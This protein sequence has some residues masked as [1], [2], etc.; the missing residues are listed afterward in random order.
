MSLSG[1][2]D[3]PAASSGYTVTP[4][5]PPDDR[6]GWS[7][8]H[9]NRTEICGILPLASVTTDRESGMGSQIEHS[10]AV[11]AGSPD[12]FTSPPPQPAGAF[13]AIA[14]L[15]DQ[16]RNRVGERYM[17]ARDAGDD[18]QAG[19]LDWEIQV[20]RWKA[21]RALEPDCEAP[22]VILECFESYPD[23]PALP[24][25]CLA[26]TK[27][28]ERF[29]W[30][31]VLEGSGG[32]TIGEWLKR[33]AARMRQ[34]QIDL[35]AAIKADHHDEIHRLLDEESELWLRREEPRI[36]HGFSGKMFVYDEIREARTRLA[37]ARAED[38]DEI[39]RLEEEEKRLWK[40]LDKVY[41]TPGDIVDALY[42][43][44]DPDSV[45]P[46]SDSSEELPFDPVTGRSKPD[47]R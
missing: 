19:R 36:L 45:K 28:G 6:S 14:E 1:S 30:D 43:L 44:V 7:T 3:L 16:A 29:V 17:E 21:R 38:R 23:H 26:G 12:R 15:C 42:Q 40:K 20:L 4:C 9:A 11:T 46:V 47:P 18:D 33:R 5:D 22:E 8:R 32:E 13:P 2:G 25:V 10:T 41:R 31:H 34:V 39:R 24:E 27:E 37:S 35:V